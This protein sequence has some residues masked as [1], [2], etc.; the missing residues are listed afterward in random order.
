MLNSPSLVN[1]FDGPGN[2][3]SIEL[4][5]TEPCKK[6]GNKSIPAV[7]VGAVI[8]SVIL[9]AAI[10]FGIWILRRRASPGTERN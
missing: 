8:G 2:D 1:S 7:A 5:G 4:C 6:K 10:M 3:T 9:L